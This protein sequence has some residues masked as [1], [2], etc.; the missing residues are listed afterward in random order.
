MDSAYHGVVSER[1]LG[2]DR[3][4]SR[5]DFLY[6]TL[7]GVLSTAVWRAVGELGA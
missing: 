6:G 1:D 7:G 3:R 5:R 2:M 4:I